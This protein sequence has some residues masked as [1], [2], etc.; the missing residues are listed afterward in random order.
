MDTKQCSVCWKKL[1]IDN[2]S[3][4]CNRHYHNKY[5]RD[6]Y[7][8]KNNEYISKEEVQEKLFQIIQSKSLIKDIRDILKRTSGDELEEF[9]KGFV[10][11]NFTIIEK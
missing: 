8:K 11:Y 7:I 9:K 4:L 5:M 6:R 10:N 1:H 2:M 3:L